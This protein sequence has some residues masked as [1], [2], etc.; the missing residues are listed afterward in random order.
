MQRD[1][2]PET[3]I[4]ILDDNMRFRPAVLKVMRRFKASQPWHGP[5]RQRIR[6]LKE[7]NRQLART[8]DIAEPAVFVGAIDGG[9]TGDSHY[10]RHEH[11][12][13]LTGRLSVVTYLH[14]FA[15]ARGM[16]E[17]DACRWSINLFRRVFPQQFAK[18][19][20]VGHMLVRPEDV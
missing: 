6:N 7:L 18:L 10:C 11:S 4:E 15:H 19:I 8:C 13:V 9:S 14:E 5:E 12:I 17:W 1:D 3:V 2:Y 20:Q 16:G